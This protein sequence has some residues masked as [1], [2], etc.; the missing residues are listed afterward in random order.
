MSTKQM[1]RRLYEVWKP[2]RWLALV[3]LA[4]IILTEALALV[5][6]YLYGRLIDSMVERAEMHE[7]FKII[8]FIFAITVTNYIV[9]EFL[10]NKIQFKHIQI[11]LQRQISTLSLKILMQ[12]SI[13]QHLNE[14]SGI[15]HSTITRGESA[16]NSLFALTVY[17]LIPTFLQSTVTTI[18]LFLLSPIIGAIVLS[19]LL[20]Y[21]S[22]AILVNRHFKK[23]LKKHYEMGR[24]NDKLQHEILRNIPLIKINSR[25]KLTAEE[26]RKDHYE[27][28][29][30]SKDMWMKYMKIAYSRDLIVIITRVLVMLVGA[31]LVYQGTYTVGFLMIIF[32]W[33][34]MAFERINWI[35]KQQRDFLE[36][37]TRAKEYFKMLGTEPDVP[38]SQN[39]IKLNRIKGAIEVRD[40]WFKYPVH[41]SEGN[42]NKEEKKMAKPENGFVLKGIDLRIEPGEVIAIVGPSGAGKSTLTSLLIRAYDPSQGKILI[43]GHDLKDLGLKEYREALGIVPQDVHLFDKSLRYN[44]LIGMNGYAKDVTE[45]EIDEIARLSCIDQFKHRLTK[46]YDTLI[47]ERGVKLSGGERQRVAIARALMKK[48][49]ALIFDEATSNLDTENEALIRDSIR[50]ASRGKT[51]IIIAHRFSTVKVADRIIVMDQ[52]Q[53][54]GQGTH[55]E[56]ISSCDV[57]HRLIENQTV[58]LGG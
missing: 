18:F 24:D 25:E 3:A 57:Y 7:V 45:K 10:T 56:L 14:N 6:P 28:T 11:P 8:G 17:N 37:W 4:L 29:E 26:F 21:V 52:G 30:Y 49:Q 39:S 23:P 16:L 35:A 22:A 27:Y 34:A 42:K 33:S 1:L 53:I 54:V 48:P 50:Q 36:N 20:I 51:S 32:S 2:F 9:I 13:G 31:Y 15:K 46:G 58:M 44:I 19:G 55:D 5:G 38:V 43:D 47:G 40:L 41:E 12:F